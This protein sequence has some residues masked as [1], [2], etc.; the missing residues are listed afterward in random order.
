M[1]NYIEYNEYFK[2]TKMSKDDHCN[3][4]TMAA[5][6]LSVQLAMICASM[7]C[8]SAEIYDLNI[9]ADGVMFK[10]S[11]KMP[12]TELAEKIAAMTDDDELEVYLRYISSWSDAGP[13][14][15]IQALEELEEFDADLVFSSLSIDDSNRYD[16]GHLYKYGI[17]DGTEYHGMVEGKPVDAIPTEGKWELIDTAV[18]MEAVDCDAKAGYELVQL[19]NRLIRIGGSQIGLYSDLGDPA[20]DKLVTGQI[21]ESAVPGWFSVDWADLK[22]SQ[23]LK[24]FA[25]V[26]AEISAWSKEHADEETNLALLNCNFLDIS[27]RAPRQ[28]SIEFGE[29]KEYSV[30]VLE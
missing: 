21:C 19:F 5:D 7:I 22:N 24:V 18:M 16:G 4:G 1:S 30:S 20:K 23:D 15:V 26:L 25:D 27:G 11:G 14:D 17:W 9:K 28:I 29:G 10:F 12:T 8:G 2:S 6:Q 13:Y 3:A